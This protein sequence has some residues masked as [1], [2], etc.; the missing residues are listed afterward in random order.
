MVHP[1][2][3]VSCLLRT[4][5]SRVLNSCRSLQKVKQIHASVVVDGQELSLVLASKLISFYVQFDDFR[6]AVS[7]LKAL[8]EPNTFLW[9]SVI[10]AHVNSGL[11]D[12]GVFVYKLM[13]KK[14][15]PCDGYT[16]PILSKLVLLIECGV[17]F[18]EMIHCVAMQMGF[19]SDVY[20]CNTMIEAYVKSGYSGNALKL[21]NEMPYRDL[22]SWTSM[23]SGF[24]YEGNS[25]LAFGLFNE[26]RKEVEPNEVTMIVMLQTCSTMVEGRQLHGYV[27][28][29]GSL[30]D[31]SLKNSI[32]KMY[33]D[34]GS[35]D[36]SELLFDETARRDVVSWNIMTYLYSSKGKIMK[37]ADYLSRMRREVQPRI[38][39]L[40]VLIAGL[41]QCRYPSQ[42]RQIH[43]LALKTGL[44]DD[45]LMTTLLEMYAKSGDL[46]NSSKLFRE[47]SHRN[48]STWDAIISGWTE[49][50]HFQ[51]ALE[52]FQQM[53][54]VG[55]QPRTENMRT[56]VV[57]CMHLGALRLGKSIHGY[58]LRN[59]FSISDE[60]AQ[61]LETS[62]MNMYVRCGD[63]CSARICFDNMLV[64]DLV[65]WSSMIEGLGT[66][67]LGSEALEFFHQMKAGGVEPNSVTFLSLLSACS[68]SGLLYKGCEALNS[69]KWEFGFEPDLDSR[70][71]G[72]LLASARVHEDHKVGQYAA[73]KLL[74]LES[75]NAGYYT[76]YSNVQASLERWNDVEEVRSAMKDM[77]LMRHPG[78]SCL[79]V[80][81][82]FHGFVSGD[83]SHQQMDE[84]HAIIDCLSEMH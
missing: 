19:E 30:I 48:Y 55:V 71:W 52:L 28:R 38:E 39:T 25:N 32:L 1:P 63:I 9:N 41:G 68:H 65:T 69:M 66:H 70:I 60:G 6:S 67:G 11:V 59:F 49:N 20:F 24:A 51:K 61:S 50:G 4:Q 83:R 10:K 3:L 7:V 33:A 73:Q 54:A 62:I 37:M 64:K 53:V 40:T 13:R 76:L 77:N 15:V 43:C 36:D 2:D 27:I 8:K 26:M 79:E 56:L 12:S 5:G 18:A 22:V 44:F 21:F 45:I 58:F 78:W 23:I 82:T 17:S 31:Q 47:V 80:E 84:I 42:G 14:G 74:E 75:D 72:A 29:F 16:F 34:F 57:A 46:E 81:G 35:E